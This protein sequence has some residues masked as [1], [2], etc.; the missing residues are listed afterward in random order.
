[1][2]AILAAVSPEWVIGLH[3]GIPWSYPG[4]L[5]R[6]KR[7]T[8]GSTVV[9]G[10][11]TWESLPRRPLPGRRNIVLSSGVLSEVE[12]YTDLKS[13]LLAVQGDLWFIGGARVYAEAMPWCERMELT[14]VPDCITHHEAVRFPPI[15]PEQWDL[16]A[17]LPHEDDPRL[18][19]R[20]LARIAST[21]T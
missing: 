17:L 5:R 13:V 20:V 15:D 8:L 4:D 10:R 12:H 18:S 19:R 2:R 9:M 21:P 11:C 6:F 7:L 16:G 1:M 3:G 14:L